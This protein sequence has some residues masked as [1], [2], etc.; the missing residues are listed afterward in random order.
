MQD[1]NLMTLLQDFF[2]VLREK[3]PKSK[4]NSEENLYDKFLLDQ[5]KEKRDSVIEAMYMVCS[6]SGNFQAQKRCM[7]ARHGKN[8]R[9]CR[10]RFAACLSAMGMECERVHGMSYW[11]NVGMRRKPT[12]IHMK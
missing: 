11:T 3:V 6:Q 8:A 2:F 4:K 9:I 1:Q 5:P 10:G 7:E 12:F